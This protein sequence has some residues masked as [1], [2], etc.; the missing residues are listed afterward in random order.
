MATI[1]ERYS[2]AINSR[3]LSVDEKTTMSDS[4]VIGAMGLAARRLET[5]W[6]PT[7]KGGEGYDIAKEPLAA[8]MERLLRGDNSAAYDL[9]RLLAKMAHEYSFALKI[10]ITLGQCEDIAKAC[11]AWHR[12]GVCGTCQGRQHPTFKGTP[13]LD[14]NTNCPDCYDKVLRHSTGKLPFDKQFRH[15]WRVLANWIKDEMAR[16][17]GRA[18]PQAMKAIAPSLDL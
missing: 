18:G 16:A 6:V 2:T 7:G 13:K 8:P 17:A 14:E 5:G 15:E 1:N 10:K 4:D 3:N 12:N 9:V 11:L